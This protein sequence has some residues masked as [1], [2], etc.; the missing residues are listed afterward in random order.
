ML[1]IGGVR[2]LQRLVSAMPRMTAARSNNFVQAAAACRQ[3]CT[4][5]LTFVEE[6]NDEEKVVDAEI[7][8]SILEVAHDND[9]D[10]EGA[11]AHSVFMGA[12][13]H[14]RVSRTPLHVN[15]GVC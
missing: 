4:I 9:I 13:T 2:P 10:L 12:H 11:C 8:K 7:G 1:R 15:I 6:A 5:K 3:L 14:P